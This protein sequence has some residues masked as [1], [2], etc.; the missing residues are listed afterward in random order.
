MKREKSHLKALG[1]QCIIR[2][3]HSFIIIFSIDILLLSTDA[4]LFLIETLI[5]VMHVAY[6]QQKY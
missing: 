4:L 2:S 1:F 6:D 5:Y 3:Y